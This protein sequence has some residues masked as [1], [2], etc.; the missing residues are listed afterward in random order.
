MVYN[1]VEDL[2]RRRCPPEELEQWQRTLGIAPP[3][4]LF[5]GNPKGM[6]K[7]WKLP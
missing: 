5:V 4:L 2:C 1:G 7:L 3:Y 6:L